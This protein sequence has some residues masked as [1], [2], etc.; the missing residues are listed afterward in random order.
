M[1][2]I[3][4]FLCIGLLLG[5]TG[6][7]RVSQEKEYVIERTLEENREQYY[8]RYALNHGREL[9]KVFG[10]DGSVLET[11]I[12]KKVLAAEYFPEE[13]ILLVQVEWV[14]G[15]QNTYLYEIKEGRRSQSFPVDA[16]YLGEGTIQYTETD[17]DGEGKTMTVNAF[18]GEEEP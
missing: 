17:E 16:V 9:W 1:K 8:G 6:C 10:A 11:M 13:D 15:T 18:T 7:T 3:M 4:L 5:Q 12:V 2:K 14:D